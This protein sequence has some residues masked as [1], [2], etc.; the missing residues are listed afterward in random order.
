MEDY[1]FTATEFFKSCQFV[2][3]ASVLSRNVLQEWR[4]VSA[5]A[6]FVT[7]YLIFMR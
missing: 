4:Y 5:A 7:N 3:N 2:R 6:N 1:I